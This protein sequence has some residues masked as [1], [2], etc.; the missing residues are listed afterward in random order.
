[1]GSNKLNHL[2]INQLIVLQM[3]FSFILS[4]HLKLMLLKND[5]NYLRGIV[6][7]CASNVYDCNRSV[8]LSIH[9][10]YKSRSFFIQMK[11]FVKFNVQFAQVHSLLFILIGQLVNLFIFCFELSFHVQQC[12]KFIIVCQLLM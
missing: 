9:L 5:G 3:S 1:M 10:M 4:F 12:G 11:I 2:E 6:N 7:T 8:Q